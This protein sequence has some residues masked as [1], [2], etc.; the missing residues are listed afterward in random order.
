MVG[1]GHFVYLFAGPKLPEQQ[2]VSIKSQGY[3]HDCTSCSTSQLFNYHKGIITIHVVIRNCNQI[4][5]FHGSNNMDS[6][7]YM[8]LCI[9]R[10]AQVK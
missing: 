9:Q 8:Y 10:N 1:E 6:Q 2:P 5:P 3:I 4:L 7:I